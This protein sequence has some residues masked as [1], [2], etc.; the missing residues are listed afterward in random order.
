[1]SVA[2]EWLV[3]PEGRIAFDDQ[4]QGPLIVLLPGLGDLRQTYRFLTPILVESGYRV[5]SVDLRG[6]GESS[7]PWADYS[8]QAVASDVLD[9]IKHLDAGPAVL[10]GNSFSAGVA[11]WAAT[12]Q[13]E[14]V[15]GV[16]MSGPFV[17][18]QDVSFMIRSAMAVMFNGPW[19][20]GAWGTFHRTL[21]TH[22]HPVD[23]DQYQR[24]LKQNLAEPGRF[25]AVKA[26][27]DRDDT[28]V[29]ER[30]TQLTVPVQIIMGE[31]DPDYP[32]PAA[33]AAWI[34]EQTDGVVVLLPN[35]GHYPQAEAPQ[36]T[37]AALL[38]WL[39]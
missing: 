7:V 39:K 14:A 24:T 11:V 32:D 4:G 19:K 18:P 26:M 31:K 38:N 20:V 30:L 25:A 33:E 15:A 29:A 5:V 37:A 9:L 34:A 3:I 35:V 21:F 13:P 28:A 2:T 8:T 16:S 27:L 17:R 1:M 6:H 23:Y 22:E 36:D 10:V 12:E